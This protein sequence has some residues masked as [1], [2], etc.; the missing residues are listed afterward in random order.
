MRS[1]HCRTVSWYGKIY[2]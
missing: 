1:S 2:A